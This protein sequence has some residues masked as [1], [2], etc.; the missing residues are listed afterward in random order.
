[1]QVG[2]ALPAHR[3]FYQ[4]THCDTAAKHYAPERI[5]AAVVELHD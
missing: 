4:R 1:M 5:V 3:E 2:P